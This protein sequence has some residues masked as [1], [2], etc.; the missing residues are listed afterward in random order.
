MK[1]AHP[2]CQTIG[3]IFVYVQRYVK[4]DFVLQEPLTKAAGCVGGLLRRQT[5]LRAPDQREGQLRRQTQVFPV[6]MP[7]K[8]Q[9][10]G[11]KR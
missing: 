6:S 7:W 3:V 8:L 4:M 9:S 10:P 11:A 2:L 5:L 1:V